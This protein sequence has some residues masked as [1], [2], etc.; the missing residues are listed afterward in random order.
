ME[1]NI[2]Q[3]EDWGKTKEE[4]VLFYRMYTY[5]GYEKKS[6]TSNYFQNGKV[7]LM[8]VHRLKLALI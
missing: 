3:E 6:R 2:I 8:I 1:R 4:K 5:K 7:V